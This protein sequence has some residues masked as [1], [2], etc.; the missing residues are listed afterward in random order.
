MSLRQKLT[1]QNLVGSALLSLSYLT[2]LAGVISGLWWVFLIGAFGSYL[3]DAILLHRFTEF[4]KSIQQ[5]R[6]GITPRT[7]LRQLLALGLLITSETATSTGIGLVLLTFLALFGLQLVCGVA[8]RQLRVHRRLPV[9]TRNIDLSSLRIPDSPPMPLI[10]E[11]MSRL[12][13]LDVFLVTGVAAF[14][15]F[16]SSLAVTVGAAVSVAVTALALA[17]VG[18]HYNRARTIPPAPKVMEFTQAWLDT[19]RPEV[20]MYFSGSSDSTYQANMWLETLDRMPRRVL[21]VLRERAIAAQLAPTRIPVLCVPAATDLMALD[22]GPARVALYPANTGKNIHMLRN[23]VIKHVFIGHGDSDKIASINP[24]S[25]VYDEVW[26]AGRAGRDRYDLARVGV[27]TDEIVEVGRPQLDE[28]STDTAPNS[29]RTVLYAPT[30]EGWTDEPGNTSLIDAGP[31]LIR[32]LL[33]AEPKVRVLYKPHPFTGMRSADARK[34]HRTIVSLIQD[35]NQGSPAKSGALPPLEDLEKR[36]AAFDADSGSTDEAHNSRE[37]GNADP[38][39]V[40]RLRELSAQWHEAYWRSRGDTEHLVIQGPRPSLYSCF[41]QADLLISDISSVVADFIATEK[42]YAVTNCEGITDDEFR[43]KHPTASAAYLFSPNGDGV[44]EALDAVHG[45]EPDR[46]A[47]ERADLRTYLLGGPDSQR[48][49]N[50]AVDDLY[51]RGCELRPLAVE[52][53]ERATAEP[54]RQPTLAS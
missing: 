34:A 14:T 7:L 27:R 43:T 33:A 39:A 28:I 40:T 18:W 8:A 16:G 46:L 9:V 30:W 17:L 49:F 15:A 35:A 42:P 5:V 24:Y 3:L 48:R 20:I 32:A 2:M 37:E 44:N 26:T 13:P 21:I 29:V 22:F 41:H 47:A 36:L 4:S 10:R 11:P 52:P 38:Q 19:Y 31:T 1:R 54:G 45:T 25:K 50:E 23:P 53:L 6:L 51:Q 12:L